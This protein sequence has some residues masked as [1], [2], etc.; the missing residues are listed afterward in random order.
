MVQVEVID[1][2]G[3]IAPEHLDRIFEP[4]FTT[5]PAGEGTG[6]GLSLC[7]NMLEEHGGTIAVQ[8]EVGLGATFRIELPVVSRPISAAPAARAPESLPPISGKAVLVVD[9]EPDIAATLAEALQGD[10]HQVE[11]AADGAKAL[12]MLGRRAFDLIVTDTKMPVLDGERFYAELERRFP[13]LCRRVLFLTGDVLSGEKRAFLERTCAP[14]L[15][16]PFDLRE[17]RQLVHRML[18]EA[19]TGAPP[20]RV[21]GLR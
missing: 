8:S 2:G 12:E 14:H 13:K 1:T 9:D 6:L 4:F 11:V 17:V 21:P 16:K 3:G 10:G 18:A 5:K 7:R 20:E 15:L 19:V